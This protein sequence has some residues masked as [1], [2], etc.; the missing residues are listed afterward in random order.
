MLQVVVGD[1]GG[2]VVRVVCSVVLS[3]S[4]MVAVVMAESLVLFVVLILVV[5]TVGVSGIGTGVGAGGNVRVPG[6]NLLL[7]SVMCGACV[8]VVGFVV[9]AVVLLVLVC[10][11]EWRYWCS[12]W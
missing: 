1:Q 9:M 4:R 3:L 2:S 6:G 11:H 10:G 7:L 5:L 8:L 12:W